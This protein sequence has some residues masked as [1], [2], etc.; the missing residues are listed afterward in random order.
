M[1]TVTHVVMD[2]RYLLNSVIVC[3]IILSVG[4][5]SPLGT[6]YLLKLLTFQHW[7]SLSA[8]YKVDFSK[9]LTYTVTIMAVDS[10]PCCPCL[11]GC[12]CLL[13]T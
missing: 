1:I 6:I 7:E 10:A 12:N 4:V 11:T 13:Y 9:Y 2:I 3:A 5:L 8:A